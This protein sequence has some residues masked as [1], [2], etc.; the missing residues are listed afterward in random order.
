[1]VRTPSA[2]CISNRLNGKKAVGFE[3]VVNLLA[4]VTVILVPSHLYHTL[5]SSMYGIL[6]ACGRAQHGP[7]C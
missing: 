2:F 6:V 7:L 1:M 5:F 3:A 4:H